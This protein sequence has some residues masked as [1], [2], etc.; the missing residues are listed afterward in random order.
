TQ[1]LVTARAVAV[2]AKDHPLSDKAALSVEDVPLDQMILPTAPPLINKLQVYTHSAGGEMPPLRVH[3]VLTGL[4]L[5]EAGLGVIVSDPLTATA[6][7]TDKTKIVPWIPDIF[8]DYG[9][10]VAKER[11]ENQILSDLLDYLGEC[12]REWSAQTQV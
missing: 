11:Q 7:A 5:A 12:S 6:F 4:R 9:Y 3:L 1:K 8:L 10:V 2:L